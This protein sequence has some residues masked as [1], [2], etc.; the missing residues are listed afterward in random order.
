MCSDLRI[1]ALRGRIKQFA[2]LSGK[3]D[4]HHFVFPIVTSTGIEPHPFFLLLNCCLIS[5]DSFF[6]ILTKCHADAP[7][8]NHTSDFILYIFLCCKKALD[9]DRFI[10]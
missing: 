6:G 7:L 9:Y 3:I 10:E 1:D 5:S 2:L 8:Y 4:V